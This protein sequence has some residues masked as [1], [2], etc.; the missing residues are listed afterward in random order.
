MILFTSAEIIGMQFKFLLLLKER[1][2]YLPLCPFPALLVK[3]ALKL[4]PPDYISLSV[5]S[6]KM[7]KA[8]AWSAEIPDDEDLNLAH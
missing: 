3:C 6:A 7:Q 4:N 5:L 8:K 1:S 2:C